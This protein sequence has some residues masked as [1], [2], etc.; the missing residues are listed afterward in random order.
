M[1]ERRMPTLAD[2]QRQ[3]WMRGAIGGLLI[4]L[5][6]IFLLLSLLKHLYYTPAGLLFPAVGPA[7]RR[8][9]DPILDDWVVLSW[10]WYLIPT[11]QL[12]SAAASTPA[13]N[14]VYILWGAMGIGL[15]GGLLCQSA[16]KRRAQITEFRQEMQREAWR[17]QAR[18]ARGHAPDDRSMTMVVGQATWHQYPAPPESWSSTTLGSLITG[19]LIVLIGLIA[20]YA[21]FQAYWSS[22]RN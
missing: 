20:E 19:L 10:L 15:I 3:V 21:F 16:R 22:G 14:F 7:L 18:A 4:M 5:A 12:P 9:I 13:W 6:V 2:A 17:E 8:H 11:W 1:P